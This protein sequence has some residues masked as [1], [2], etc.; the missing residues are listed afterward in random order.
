[1]MK[2]Y[3]AAELVEQGKKYL[4]LGKVCTARELFRYALQV[5]PTYGPAI[6]ELASYYLDYGLIEPSQKYIHLANRYIAD[7]NVVQ[8]LQA[9]W[10]EQKARLDNL[11]DDSI[12]T[13]NHLI[14]QGLHLEAI[15]KYVDAMLLYQHAR[16]LE[17]N[18]PEVLFLIDI[19]AGVRDGA[20]TKYVEKLFDDYSGNFENHLLQGLQYQTPQLLFSMIYDLHRTHKKCAD[21]GCGSGLL[22]ALLKNIVFD[23]DGVDLSGE[24]L[25]LARKKECYQRLFHLDIVAFLQRNHGYDLICAADVFVYFGSLKKVFDLV[26]SALHN[27]GIFVFSIE[28]SILPH[29]YL[30]VTGRFVHPPEYVIQL[31]RNLGFAVLEEKQ[32]HIRKDGEK[33]ILGHAFILQ[34]SP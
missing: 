30:T 11:P 5:E 2:G 17:P 31:A 27:G 14:R 13:A 25:S 28:T 22:G 4:T 18:N 26:F 9:R 6:I 16:R 19:F 12:H 3:S 7:S 15:G 34:K 29:H 23:I 10:D 1:M 20:P 21:L 33:W 8:Q 32:I 24:M